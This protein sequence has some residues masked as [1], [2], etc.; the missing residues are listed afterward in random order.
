M[1]FF[2]VR[3]G[4]NQIIN[5]VK[6]LNDKK[7][8]IVFDAEIKHG[9]PPLN[10]TDRLPSVKYCD[11]WQDFKGMGV[12][13]VCAYDYVHDR[14]VRFEDESSRSFQDLIDSR[15]IIVG[16]N[17]I[18]YDQHLLAENWGIS[19]PPQKH[20]DLL[21]EI[22]RAAGLSSKYRAPTHSGFNLRAC[23]NAN[24]LSYPEF[25]DAKKIHIAWQRGERDVVYDHCRLD[26]LRTKELLNICID[27]NQAFVHPVKSNI[28]LNVVSPYKW[29]YHA[30]DE[31]AA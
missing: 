31:Q 16:F 27:P 17:S 7:R 19:I 5:L 28:F 2:S 22:W 13:V 30:T 12:S 11:G 24:C 18:A 15:D 4:V 3:G 25:I 6:S 26:V 1:P 14:Y 9:I 8:I 21:V 23:C 20:Y 29:G 10:D